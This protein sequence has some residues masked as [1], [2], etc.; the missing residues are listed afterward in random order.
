MR[1][2][3]SNFRLGELCVSAHALTLFPHL[4]VNKRGEQI[5]GDFLKLTVLLDKLREVMTVH[6]GHLNI[7]YQA[8]NLIEYITAEPSVTRNVIPCVLAV[9]KRYHVLVARV[10]QRIDNKR[11]EYAFALCPPRQ[12]TYR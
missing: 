6:F 9:V 8:G 5:N 1:D 7:A 2:K 10:M 11:I 12:R 3:L 4:L